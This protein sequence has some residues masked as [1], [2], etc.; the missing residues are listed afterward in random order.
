M[1]SIQKL[2]TIAKIEQSIKYHISEIIDDN[3]ISKKMDYVLE[4]VVE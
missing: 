3:E 1:S 4:K 2:T